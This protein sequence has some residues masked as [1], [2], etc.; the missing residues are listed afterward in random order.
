MSD[1]VKNY[2]EQLIGKS[3]LNKTE[4]VYLRTVYNTHNKPRYEGC[5]CGSFER[6][7]F[8]SLFSK[9]FVIY[10]FNSL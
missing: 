7:L 10:V 6:K 9:W 5:L 8:L 2:I 3:K 4:A 1:E